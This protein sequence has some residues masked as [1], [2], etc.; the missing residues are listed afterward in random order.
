MLTKAR[1]FML[2]LG[3]RPQNDDLT[4]DEARDEIVGRIKYIFSDEVS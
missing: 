3:I 2:Q 1:L 4:V